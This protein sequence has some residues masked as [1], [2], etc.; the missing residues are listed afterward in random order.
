VTVWQDENLGLTER[1]SI[2]SSYGYLLLFS[3]VVVMAIVSAEAK[4]VL[5][6]GGTLIFA[7]LFCSDALSLFGRWQLWLFIV[8]SLLLSPLVIGEKDISLCGLWVSREGLWAGLWMTLRALS[9]ALAASIFAGAVSAPQMARIFER[10]RLKG[11]GFALGV[12][13]NMLPTIQE[14]METSYQALRLRGGFRRGRLETVRLL[15]VAIIAGSLR[16]GDDIVCAAEARA[17]DPTRSQ[18]PPLHMTRADLA[19]VGV[20]TLLGLALLML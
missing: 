11:L 9:I 5:V 19:L 14:T 20:L 18:G 3:T 8:P 7:V 2:F 10:L 16:R 1:R 17:F 12:A 13:T 4:V 6:L 15:L